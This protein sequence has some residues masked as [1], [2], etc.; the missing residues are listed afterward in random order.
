VYIQGAQTIPA[1]LPNTSGAALTMVTVITL[2]IGIAV[3]ATTI[4]RQVAK[5]RYNA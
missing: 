4:A 5:K 1:V 2:A 3:I